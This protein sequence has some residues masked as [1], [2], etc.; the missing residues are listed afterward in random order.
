LPAISF[1][2]AADFTFG[3]SDA[4]SSQTVR[5]NATSS[6]RSARRARSMVRTAP[7][8]PPYEPDHRS[9]TR[10]VRPTSS[11]SRYGGAPPWTNAAYVDACPN[12]RRTRISLEVEVEIEVDVAPSS[13]ASSRKHPSRKRSMRPWASEP[14]RWTMR[15]GYSN[16]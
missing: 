10:S 1:V 16:S 4:G 6:G 8:N 7:W 3:S 15:T 14:S 5:R 12:A 9:H 2:T 13:F 11:T